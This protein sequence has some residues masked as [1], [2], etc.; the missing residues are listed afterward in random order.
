MYTV[1][2]K[3]ATLYFCNDFVETYYSEMIIGTYIHVP[4]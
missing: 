3:T 4:R 1:G 2:Q